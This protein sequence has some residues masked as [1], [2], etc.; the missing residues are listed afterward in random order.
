M[1]DAV[2]K[3]EEPVS[4][5]APASND[6]Q[7]QQEEPNSQNEKSEQEPEAQD[8]GSHHADQESEAVG[9][10]SKKGKLKD[11]VDEKKKKAYEMANPRNLPIGDLGTGSSDP[12]VIA[13]L[14]SHGIKP[15]HKEDPEMRLRTRTIQKDTN[16]VWN[17]EWIVAGVPSSGFKLKCRLYDEDAND[18]D[19]RLGNVTVVVPH[20]SENWEGMRETSFPVKKRMAAGARIS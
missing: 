18:S 5:D 11:K 1:A 13:T 9:K 14:T 3:P 4:N 6:T 12:C 15:R 10:R 17:Q 8:G 20:I 7:Q 16:P 2:P 19:D